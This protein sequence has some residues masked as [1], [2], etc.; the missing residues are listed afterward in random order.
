MPPI[1]PVKATLDLPSTPILPRR[2]RL[3][4]NTILG[5][6]IAAGLLVA[7]LVGPLVAPYNPVAISLREKLHTP[8]WQHLLGTDE[9]GRDILSRLLTGTRLT[10]GLALGA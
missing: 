5:L 10:M 4:G 3:K 1:S 2:R 8:S 9:L 6:V 7:V